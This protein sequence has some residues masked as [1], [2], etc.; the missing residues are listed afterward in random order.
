M[1]IRVPAKLF[2]PLLVV[3]MLATGVA[4]SIFNKYQDLQCVAHCDPKDPRPQRNFESPVF[5]T[6]VMFMGE[7]LCL[8]PVFA[9]AL[10]N[11]YQKYSAR[12]GGSG[13]AGVASK[14]SNGAAYTAVPTSETGEIEG[15]ACRPTTG[16]IDS[17][18]EH[19]QRGRSLQQERDY[20]TASSETDTDAEAAPLV[21]KKRAAFAVPG[22]EGRVIPAGTDGDAAGPST[23]RPRA[24]TLDASVSSVDSALATDSRAGSRTRP[25]LSTRKS[26]RPRRSLSRR[27][28]YKAEPE[29]IPLEGR[30]MF[31]FFAPT[32]C[33]ICGTTLMNVGLI[34]TPVSIYQMTRGALVLWVGVFS[35]IFLHRHLHLFQWLS[36]MT[37]MLGVCIVGLSGTLFSG[38]TPSEPQ[39]LLSSALLSANTTSPEAALVPVHPGSA[40]RMAQ[41]YINEPLWERSSSFL[42]ARG[43]EPELP[44]AA[45][46]L[47]GVLLILFAQLFTA[48]QF[49]LEEKIMGKYSVEPL[50]AVGLEGAFGMSTVAAAGP[51]L[52]YFIGRTP[53]G[54]G[55][56]FDFV[57]CWKQVQ[58]N[59]RIFYS[60]FAI[61]ASISLFNFFGLSVTRSI[62]ATARST[63]DTSRTVGI[64]V[65]SLLLGWEVF[66]PLNG[67]LQ[68]LGFFFLVYGTFV[69]N[70][71]AKPP[72][73]LRP[74]PPSPRPPLR[75]GRSSRYRSRTRTRSEPAPVSG[76]EADSEAAPVA[77]EG[78]KDPPTG[79]L[80]ATETENGERT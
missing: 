73:F 72:K 80:V 2:L 13:A 75:R 34:F 5:Q 53:D 56:Y 16:G 38:N 23:P 50:L 67:S 24:Q 76:N 26:S 32:V 60:S 15:T 79:Q 46:A 40:L 9:Q 37:V 64:W 63:I 61:M 41:T 45:E 42:H 28:S 20:F 1:G 62:S 22:E 74:P 11:H 59:S 35:V 55:G 31:L 77:A 6:F 70:G 39:S 47:L 43:E 8:L 66:K 65:V 3:G 33:D 36:L 12:R 7:S 17:D 71:I 29:G 21:S 78:R 48:G 52:Y 51:F 27:K 18:A 30:A 10:Y 44:E 57:E 4:N 49:V 58:G 19:G 54:Q 69:F 14:T 25:S 68:V